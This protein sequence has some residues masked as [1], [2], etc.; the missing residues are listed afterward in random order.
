MEDSKLKK[1]ARR[2]WTESDGWPYQAFVRFLF[3][4]LG[5]INDEVFSSRIM[6][7]ADILIDVM[8]EGKNV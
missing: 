7:L 3:F 6:K 4:S 2:I 5:Y 1:E 8:K